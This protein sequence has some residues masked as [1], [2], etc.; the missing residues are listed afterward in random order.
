MVASVSGIF[1]EVIGFWNCDVKYAA[2]CAVMLFFRLEVK[3][4]VVLA[5]KGDKR[6]EPYAVKIARTVLRRGKGSNRSFL[7]CVNPVH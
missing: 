2:L 1:I 3:L 7:F 5:D 4:R 6:L